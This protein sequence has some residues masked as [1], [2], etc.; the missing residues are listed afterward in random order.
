MAIQ[1]EEFGASNRGGHDFLGL[2]IIP[3]RGKRQLLDIEAGW[4][5]HISST[6]FKLGLSNALFNLGVEEEPIAKNGI[7][8][9]RSRSNVEE[10]RDQLLLKSTSAGQIIT[11]CPKQSL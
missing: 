9:E 8:M 3:C 7:K 5:L 10:Q 11:Y 2:E 6:T 1:Y 4:W